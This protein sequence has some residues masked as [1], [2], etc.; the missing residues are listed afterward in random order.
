[1]E[2]NRSSGVNHLRAG[3]G[4]DILFR[5]FLRITDYVSTRAVEN[6]RHKVEISFC[7]SFNVNA[8]EVLRNSQTEDKNAQWQDNFFHGNAPEGEYTVKLMFFQFI[9]K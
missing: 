8:K 1:V 7:K 3:E 9:E 4:D 6:V 2:K 5:S